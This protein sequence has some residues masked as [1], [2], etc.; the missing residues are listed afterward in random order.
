[1]HTF[2]ILAK[3]DDLDRVIVPI[4]RTN[5]SETPPAGC[6][7]A[8]VEFDESG[9]VVAYQLLQ[10]AIFLEGLWARDN[11]A[12]LRHLYNLGTRYAKEIGAERI[13]TITRQDEAGNRIGKLA[14]ALGLEKMNWNVYRRTI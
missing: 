5:G 4:L 13:M 10:N 11:S 3:Q 12:N 9:T 8:A 14:E 2:K 6:Y 7:V 1:M